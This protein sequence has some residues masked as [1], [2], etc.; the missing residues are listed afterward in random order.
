MATLDFFAV[1]DDLLDLLGFIYS[2]TD[3]VVY[4]SYS[5]YDSE[6]R[7]FIS[8]Q[9]L[10]AAF[11]I[12]DDPHGNGSAI[13]LQLHSPSVAASPSIRRFR[14]SVPGYSFPYC[15]ESA[16]L[17]QLYLGIEIGR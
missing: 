8:V 3:C 16:G 1:R 9:Q 12:G 6:L 14:L 7:Q 2:E 4:E 10:D 13:L 17:M 15:V 11:S 5:R